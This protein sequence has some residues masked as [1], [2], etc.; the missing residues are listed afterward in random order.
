MKTTPVIAPEDFPWGWFER[1]VFPERLKSGNQGRRMPR[2]Y[3]NL[4]T[5]FDIETTG[6]PD[7][8]ESIMYVWQW[9]FGSKVTVM[10]RTWEQLRSFITELLS[11]IR[12]DKRQC[13]VIL[14]HNLSYEFQFLRTIYRFKPQEVFAVKSRRILK[15]SMYDHRLEFRCTY[16]HS[17]MSLSAYTRKIN[18]DHQK[19]SGEEYDYTKQRF[20]W[21]PLTDREIMYCQNDVLGLVEA[22]T[23]ELKRDRDTLS[24]IPMTSTGYVRRDAKHAMRLTS[25]HMLLRI[26]PDLAQYR[27]LRNAF[28]GGDTHCNRYYNG[29]ILENVSSADR[30]SSYPDVICN[31]QFPMTPFRW[32]KPHIRNARYH[33]KAGHAVAFR[34]AFWDITM[35]DVY[36]GFPYIPRSKC[37]H[38]ENGIYDNGR[39]LCADY[40]EICV[41]DIDFRIIDEQYKWKRIAV[42]EGMWSHYGE[43]PRPL[44]LTAIEY[45]RKKTSLK[46]V[47][48]E[49]GSAEYM[50]ARSKELLNSLYGMMAQDP[51]KYDILFEEDSEDIFITKDADP[52]HLLHNYQKKAFL[53]YQWGVWVTAHSRAELREGLRLAGHNAVYCDTDSVKYLGTVDWTEYN[54]RHIEASLQSGSH[55]TDPQGVEHFMGVFE[56]ESHEPGKPLYKNFKTLGSKKYAYVYQDGSMGITVAGVNKRLG[57]KELEKA[58]GLEVFKDGFI[59]REAGGTEVVY[60]D[61][62]GSRWLHLEDGD[63]ELGPNVYL[64][65]STYKLGS[66]ED[67]IRILQTPG[68]FDRMRKQRI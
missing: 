28:R 10:G 24:S 19:L 11:R 65:D 14:V 68:L 52:E 55:A 20:P 50:Y 27:L 45:Y 18:V 47:K 49:D 42:V 22:Y 54:E 67:Y 59:F 63:V 8:E 26:Q 13:L 32:F 40:L 25:H 56:D 12:Q 33:M 62:P 46:G 51:I 36:D 34:V 35:K 7:L 4:V 31:K 58:G 1:S 38:L 64:R 9:Q 3:L 21:T 43:L 15:C 29:F 39:V 30:S 23:E 44:V 2:R 66:A 60:N 6:L 48:S 17:N 16:L 41:T 61:T 37:F 57:A 53:A 5:A